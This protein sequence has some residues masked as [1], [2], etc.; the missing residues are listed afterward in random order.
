MVIILLYTYKQNGQEK[1]RITVRRLAKGERKD[2]DG[3]SESKGQKEV[4][5]L[6]SRRES[7]A[8]HDVIYSGCRDNKCNKLS[9]GAR[10]RDC[11]NF[12]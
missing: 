4:C 7:Y 11:L 5:P 1:I 8:A 2:G 12:I 10:A 6:P 9:S 3:R